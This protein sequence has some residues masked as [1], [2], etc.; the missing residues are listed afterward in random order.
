MWLNTGVDP[1]TN[2]TI[3]PD[4]ADLTTARAIVYGNTTE[5]GAAISITGYGVGWNRWS[6]LGH[7]VCPTFYFFLL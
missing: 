1:V 6:Y 3:V 4:Y 7:D 5:L 2:Q